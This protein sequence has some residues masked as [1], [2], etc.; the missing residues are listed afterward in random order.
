M[1]V[2]TGLDRLRDSGFSGLK[3]ARVAL[4]CH[5]ASVDSNL[6]HVLNL[7]DEAGIDVPLV[8][9]PEHGASGAAQDM[10]S[11]DGG[12]HAS[13]GAQASERKLIS[14]YADTLE[15]LWPT[16][17]ILEGLDVLVVDLQ[18]VGSRYYTFAVSMRYCMEVCAK[19]G[20]RVVVLD[21]PNPL[22][23]LTVEGSV[24]GN[25][26]RS[27]V[28]GFGVPVR[29]GLSLGELARLAV[30]E[31]VDA[32]LEV[33]SMKGWERR[34]F[35]DETGLPWVLPSPNM[36]TLATAMVYPGSCLFEASNLSEGRGT[37]RP[38]EFL[39]APWLNSRALASAMNQAGLPG[40]RFRPVTFRPMFHKH[41]G[42]DCP[43]VQIHVMD[44]ERFKPFRTGVLLL[45]AVLKQDRQSFA[46]R[47]EPYEFVQDPP[48]LD[49]LTGSDELRLLLDQGE[50]VEPLL[51]QWQQQAT[52]FRE[53][54]QDSLLYS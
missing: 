37:T 42:K 19:V 39:G 23:G 32:E 40:V 26:L 36:P 4:L 8:L 9:G 54:I 2:L 25:E 46:W 10:E 6:V 15:S 18:D 1:S 30:A 27:F 29:H 38:F 48:A 12:G 22:G 21:R 34:M 33:I 3:G 45:D 28:G 43:G 17:E 11:V 5:P 13:L 41:A 52:E 50:E 31:G 53:T 51:A 20:V 24:L 16:E 49:M 14:L 35:F 44:R 7:M 47:K